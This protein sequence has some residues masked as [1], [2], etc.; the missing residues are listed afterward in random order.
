MKTLFANVTIETTTDVVS[1]INELI[2]KSVPKA[3]VKGEYH[4]S[5]PVCRAYIRENDKY[6]HDCGQALDQENYEI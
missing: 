3:I 4:N 1:E 5:C 6:C 2:K